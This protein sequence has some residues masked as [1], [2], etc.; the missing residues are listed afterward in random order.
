M[1]ISFSGIF[2]GVI[3]IGV[4]IFFLAG[5]WGAYTE[6]KHVQDYH[7]R[8]VGHITNKH[9]KLGSD[10]GGNYYVEYWFMP[11]NGSKITANSVVAKQ[12]WDM[13][14]VDDT[15][16]IRFDRS[17]PNR[18]IPMY[19]GS[20]SLVFAFFMLVMAAVFI[21]FGGSRLFYSFEKRKPLK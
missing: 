18:N 10:G 8:A 17:N 9:F 2:W 12:Q 6:N 7:G 15:F 5:S 11:S 4:G 3:C 19:G 20:P 1:K 21:I 13:L 16:E 14:R